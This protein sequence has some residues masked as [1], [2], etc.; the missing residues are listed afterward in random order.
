MVNRRVHS[1]ASLFILSLIN[2]FCTTVFYPLESDT[3]Y[4]IYMDSIIKQPNNTINS[5]IFHNM[6]KTFI[7]KTNHIRC[8]IKLILFNDD[9][10]NYIRIYRDDINPVFLYN[11]LL[12]LSFIL[13]ER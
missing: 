10:S 1:E 7:S 11:L 13:Y 6:I 12:I 5:K 3:S 4:L 8:F 2:F 9:N